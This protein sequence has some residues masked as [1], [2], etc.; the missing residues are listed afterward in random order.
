MLRRLR[1]RS[2]EARYRGREQLEDEFGGDSS[3]GFSSKKLYPS[4]RISSS[5]RTDVSPLFHSKLS[6]EA[7]RV[8]L[9]RPFSLD[10]L[11]PLS[12][13]QRIGRVIGLL[14]N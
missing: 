13:A 4:C 10:D 11:D 1:D 14:S 7:C 8:P 6:G 3:E 12:N 9:A 5:L 2:C